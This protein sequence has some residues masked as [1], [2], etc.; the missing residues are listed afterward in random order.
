[1]LPSVFFVLTTVFRFVYFQE[2]VIV[3]NQLQKGLIMKKWF[4]SVLT[5]LVLPLIMF[6][7]G[8]RQ[9][10]V[11]EV[12]QQP[13]NATIYTQHNLWY[14]TGNTISSINY[15]SGR[16]LRLGTEVKIISA[17]DSSIKFKTGEGKVFTIDFKPE[18]MMLSMPAYIKQT[19]TLK[20]SE[21]LCSGLNRNQIS[22]IMHGVVKKGMTRREVLLCCGPPPACRTPSVTCDTWVYWTDRYTTVRVVFKNNKVVEIISLKTL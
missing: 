3:Y 4:C 9:I 19:F 11:A 8:C 2:T 20:S 22:D 12:L 14:D 18:W 15:Q 10:S 5:I 1:M 6:T 16:L 13:Q 21:K 17:T 7:A